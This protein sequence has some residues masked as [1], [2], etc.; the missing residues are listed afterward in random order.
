MAQARATA[1]KPCKKST[2]AAGFKE[3]KSS[4]N[5]QTHTKDADNDEPEPQPKMAAKSFQEDED[6]NMSDLEED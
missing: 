6:L 2:Q 4:P 3:K 1:T 5:N